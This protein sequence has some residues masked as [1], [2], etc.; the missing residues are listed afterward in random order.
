M[1][2]WA[3]SL[4]LLGLGACS[5]TKT[6]DV[7]ASDLSYADVPTEQAQ[8]GVESLAQDSQAAAKTELPVLRERGRGHSG[9]VA[10]RLS[11]FPEIANQPVQKDGYV[12]N[13]YVF[14]RN[15]RNWKELSKLLYG[16]EDRAELLAQW[17]ANAVVEPGAVVYYNSPFRPDDATQL[18]SFDADFGM[19]LTDV[20]VAAG[21]TL[22]S[23]AAKVYGSPDAWREIA[24]ANT[25]SL[26]HPDVIEIGQTLHVAPSARETAP[27]LAAYVQKVQTDAQL[28]LNQEA[29]AQ[30]EQMAQTPAK[31]QDVAN[32]VGSQ[33]PPEAASPAA[34]FFEQLDLPMADIAIMLGCLIAVAALVV[35]YTRRRKKLQAENASNTI[36]FGKKKTGTED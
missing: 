7:N 17:N 2:Y 5:S 4:S 1:K 35:S 12:L 10:Y 18:K 36:F 3:L 19:T 28:A 14:V 31:Q 27:I 30:T 9:G 32:T 25:D 6:A 22:S 23:I 33:A 15:E 24:A 34:S 13:G 20:S 8:E 26:S 29:P 16:R 21:D 11:R